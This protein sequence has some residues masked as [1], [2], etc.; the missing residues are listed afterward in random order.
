MV[1]VDARPTTTEPQNTNPAIY[2]IRP[3]Q[4]F[5]SL[6]NIFQSYH[7]TSPH[8]R[9]RNV[10]TICPLVMM[11]LVKPPSAVLTF[12]SFVQYLLSI[13]QNQKFHGD[14][15]TIRQQKYT[16]KVKKNCVILSDVLQRQQ[17]SH[18]SISF[19]RQYATRQRECL[20]RKK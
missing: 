16:K 11:D 8:L 15:N 19:C 4:N 6:G 10:K 2:Q 5:R 14:I 17:L 20:C 12:Q 13:T 3:E 7:L 1:E 9:A 18:L